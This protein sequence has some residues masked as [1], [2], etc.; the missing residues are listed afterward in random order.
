ML[1]KPVLLCCL[2]LSSLLSLAQ[3]K[4]S[5][6][7]VKSVYIRNSGEIMD[8]EELK[9]YFTFYVSD[10]VDRKTNEYTLQILDKNLARVKD[11]KF[12]DDKSVQLLEASYNNSSILFLFYNREDKTFEF[13]AYGFDGKQKFTYT[14]EF[15]KRSKAYMEAVMGSRSD[16]GQNESLFSVN[17]EGFVTVFPV[18]EKKYYS[19]EI[20]FF[21][22]NKR[23]QWIYEAAEE[24]EDKFSNAVYLGCTDSIVVFEVMKQKTLV[25]SNGPH[26]WLLGLNIFTGKKVFELS[27]EGEEYKFYPMNISRIEGKSDFLLM[28]TYYDKKS[29]VMK[30]ASLG[31]ASWTMNSKGVISNKV[32]NSWAEDISKY[33][34][35]NKKG[36]VA[37]V[38]FIYFH[39]VFQTADGNFFAVGEGYKQEVSALGVG[40]RVLGSGNVS[41]L[42]VVTTDLLFFRFDPNFKVTDVKIYDKENNT[43]ELPGG[44]EFL[45]PHVMALMAKAMGAFDYNFTTMDKDHTRFNVGYTDYTKKEEE[46]KGRYFYSIGYK[47]GET[48]SDKI[49]LNTKAKWCRVYPA[50]PG[51]VTILEYYK[52]EKRLE[53]RL[54]KLN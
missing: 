35:V 40:L 32:Y 17:E 4:L 43:C 52:K 29:R 34:P 25:F 46:G 50:K 12:E 28:G 54:E 2:L 27:T 22:T 36:N 8:G 15:D 10:K 51:F 9:G 41:M 26:S 49:P 42:N 19:F 6:E 23:K 38:G 48:T 45:S 39:K 7:N 47:D 16:E 11:I 37:K 1:Q 30:D 53:Y 20:N 18:R 24:Q 3:E 13:R 14:K 33:V 31:L 44:A 21:A 5:I